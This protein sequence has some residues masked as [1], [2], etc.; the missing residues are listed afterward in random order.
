MET[1]AGR[2]DEQKTEDRPEPNSPLAEGGMTGTGADA[3]RNPRWL[4]AAETLLVTVWLLV[5]T[6][7]TVLCRHGWCT[8][9]V[10]SADVA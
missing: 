6:G 7:T 8:C 2:P 3:P 5:L 9:W 10:A 1:A 4:T